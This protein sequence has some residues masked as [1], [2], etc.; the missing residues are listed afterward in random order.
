MCVPSQHYDLVCIFSCLER[1]LT[2][3][4]LNISSITGD[5]S[6][7]N[8]GSTTT[9]IISNTATVVV[10]VGIGWSHSKTGWVFPVGKDW[11]EPF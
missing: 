3:F 9:L 8:N 11:L 10:V 2:H 1:K 6:S 5:V 7:G 4:G